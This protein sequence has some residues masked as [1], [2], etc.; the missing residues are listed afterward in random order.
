MLKTAITYLETL[1][2]FDFDR[3]ERLLSPNAVL[4]DPTAALIVGETIVYDGR[5]EVLAGIERSSAQARNGGFEI[6]TSFVSGEYVVLVVTYF[7]E[8][9]GAIADRP[10]EWIP[11]RI[12]GVT[13][14]RVVNGL[15][16]EHLDHVDYS[17]MLEQVAQV[18]RA[19]PSSRP[20][21]PPP[22]RRG[23]P[24]VRESRTPSMR[25]P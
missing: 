16:V 23:E 24:D 8:L 3:L 12:G 13:I 25:V 14:V 20:S 7:S 2:E 19:N 4:R 11:V 21:T 22:G 9:D 6:T 10:G 1:Y 18:D 15:V 5:D 17:A